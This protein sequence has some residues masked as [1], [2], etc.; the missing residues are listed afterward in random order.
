ML[1]PWFDLSLSDRPIC[2]ALVLR[3]GARSLTIKPYSIVGEAIETF[4]CLAFKP[5]SNSPRS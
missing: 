4:R 3:A 2:W 1:E 5:R